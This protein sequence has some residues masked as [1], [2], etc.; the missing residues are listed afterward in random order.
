MSSLKLL[1]F[2]YPFIV[3]IHSNTNHPRVTNRRLSKIHHNSYQNT[4]LN[5]DSAKN[6]VSVRFTLL[7]NIKEERDTLLKN[8]NEERGIPEECENTEND[9][10][11]EGTD[12]VANEISKDEGA[13]DSED[14]QKDVIV[15]AKKR[16][17][18]KIFRKRKQEME[19]SDI[20]QGEVV[21]WTFSALRKNE[22]NT[23][24]EHSGTEEK[25][26]RRSHNRNEISKTRKLE[27]VKW[28]ETTAP[29]PVEHTSI[30]EPQRGK[31]KAD[32]RIHFPRY[33][34]KQ[35]KGTG[36]T[37]ASEDSSASDEPHS[38]FK[39]SSKSNSVSTKRHQSE[40]KASRSK[41]IKLKRRNKHNKRTMDWIRQYRERQSMSFM[42][43]FH[44]P[45]LPS[46][47]D[48]DSPV[49]FKNHGQVT[50]EPTIHIVA[51]STLTIERQFRMG[52]VIFTNLSQQLRH[53]H[54]FK[55]TQSLTL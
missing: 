3:N 9:T 51:I 33:N 25:N 1:T 34:S 5:M 28:Q 47:P 40:V 24:R 8:I 19:E 6:D 11:H 44:I 29:S 20:M 12:E 30:L 22:E 36:F 13:T 39:K 41:R 37:T 17:T 38:A 27:K 46:L 4:A 54:S 23:S 50:T 53:K 42:E 16:P 31:A 18:R 55:G 35:Q 49:V 10:T 32:S 2:C 26:Y 7:K 14:S 15:A 45:P 52:I 21:R 43:E 48:S